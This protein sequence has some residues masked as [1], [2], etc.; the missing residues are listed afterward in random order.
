[1][2]LLPLDRG[3]ARRA[4]G[5]AIQRLALPLTAR[6]VISHLMQDSYRFFSDTINP[7]NQSKHE[8]RH[9][10]FLLSSRV[11]CGVTALQQRLVVSG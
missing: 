3:A 4:E 10:T 7:S 2:V 11:M 9:A 6:M 5:Y 1:M 8:T